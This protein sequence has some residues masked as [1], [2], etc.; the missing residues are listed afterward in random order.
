MLIG[1][2]GKLACPGCK[3]LTAQ[4]MLVMT[5]SSGCALPGDRRFQDAWGQVVSSRFSGSCTSHDVR[6]S[7]QK[8][9]PPH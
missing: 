7:V 5:V 8:H 4:Q 6:R 9:I 3:I 1:K 2:T